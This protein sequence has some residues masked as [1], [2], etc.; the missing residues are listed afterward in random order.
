[1]RGF[2][3]MSVLV[4]AVVDQLANHEAAFQGVSQ[5]HGKPSSGVLFDPRARGVLRHDD[6][7]AAAAAH[8]SRRGQAARSGEHGALTR[9]FVQ[10][11]RQ[12]YGSA[13]VY[14]IGELHARSLTVGGSDGGGAAPRASAR[15]VVQRQVGFSSTRT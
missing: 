4:P 11:E 1:M 14:Q 3:D 9:R 6:G 13:G 15:C 2:F 12:R 10:F 8:S 7:R 5:P